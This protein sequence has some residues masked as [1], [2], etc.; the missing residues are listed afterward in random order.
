MDLQG[1]MIRFQ[2]IRAELTASIACYNPFPFK[3]KII[4]ANIK[5]QNIIIK[6]RN[7]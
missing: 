2:K 3:N 7:A 4:H 5:R 6:N 1:K